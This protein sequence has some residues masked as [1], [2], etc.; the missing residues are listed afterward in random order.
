MMMR[1]K[2][3]EDVQ[4]RFCSPPE[5]MR[6]CDMRLS[7]EVAKRFDKLAVGRCALMMMKFIITV[8]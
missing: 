5:K 2:I 6:C 4:K 8:R 7:N 1:R 3:Q